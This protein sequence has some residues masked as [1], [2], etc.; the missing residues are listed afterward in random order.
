MNNVP[1]KK[2]RT[3]TIARIAY[4]V[5]P[6]V[7]LGLVAA[8]IIR[9]PERFSLLEV[10]PVEEVAIQWTT[11]EPNLIV[12]DVVNA[13]PDP[14]TIAQV[15]VDEAYW[16]FAMTPEGGT[17]APRQRGTIRIPYP[18]VE[19]EAHEVVLVSK[20]GI[21]FATEIPVAI[22]S[23]QPSAR[24]FRFFVLLGAIIGVIPVALGLM[25]Y[26]LVRNL[27]DRWV[28]FL[29]AFTVGLLLF[30][31]IDTVREGFEIAE[32][33]PGF[34]QGAALLSGV[35]VLVFLG[36]TAIGRMGAKGSGGAPASTG[37]MLAF[38][39]ALG[40][41]LHNVGEGLA[42]GSA[43]VLGEVAVG[44]TLVLGFTLHNITEGLA[45][46][47]PLAKHGRGIR[48]L[49]GLGA[50]AGIPTIAGTLIG[51][52]TYSTLWA[53]IFFAVAAGAIFQV[54]YVIATSPA[55][56]SASG[57]AAL[58]ENFLGLFLGLAVMYA[59]GLLVAV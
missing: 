31:G 5:L 57:N 42:V 33:L 28:R 32:A 46:V 20:T 11:L 8:A 41:G 30:L 19:A 55:I 37:M 1:Q 48:Y 36:L 51:G 22:A 45:I 38:M 47:V 13:G 29:L 27:S 12:L 7:I 43:Y 54:V 3:P 16:Q 52:F 58:A 44:T 26:P 24:S 15:M 53:L 17:L 21:T 23:P 25:W 39:I 14:V 10:P 50:I 9:Y 40:I 34:Y 4:A 35:G 6:L 2:S 18:W 59:T 56:R 49:L